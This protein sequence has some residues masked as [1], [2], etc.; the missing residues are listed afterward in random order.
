MLYVTLSNPK[1]EIV[2]TALDEPSP[3][4]FEAMQIYLRSSRQ[5]HGQ[6]GM[7][8]PPREGRAVIRDPL[9][10]WK[11]RTQKRVC[12]VQSAEQQRFY[13]PS[14]A[15][16]TRNTLKIILLSLLTSRSAPTIDLLLRSDVLHNPVLTPSA[17]VFC[18]QDSCSTWHIGQSV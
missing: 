14:Y 13:T 5:V 4:I 1:Y 16:L 15:Y 2:W 12:V 11:L 10:A 8:D 17:A 3:T 18:T 7:R 6:R 9:P